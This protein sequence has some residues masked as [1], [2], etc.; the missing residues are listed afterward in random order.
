MP[1]P[2]RADWQ[3]HDVA[4]PIGP[5]VL[6]VQ[7]SPTVARATA[8][9]LSEGE[10]EA[11]VTVAD[12][13][14]A[15]RAELTDG[16]HALATDLLV[17]DLALPG[18]DALE[19]LAEVRAD[20]VSEAVPVVVLSGSS[21]QAVVQRSYQLGANCF[22]RK[23]NRVVDL[24]PATRAIERF[25]QRHADPQGGAEPMFQLPL[26]P[27]ASAVRDARRSVRDLFRAWGLDSLGEI[28]ELCTSEL[29]TNAVL[30][31]RS[32]VLLI[33][34]A[35]RDSV[36]VEVEDEAP[37]Q[38]APGTLVHDAETGRGLALVDAMAHAWGVDQH[39]AG[40]T[41]WFEL[42]RPTE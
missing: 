41:V 16:D 27:T 5:R 32:P 42:R 10:L 33:V 2:A 7:D 19:L 12:S 23:P 9:L 24:V 3:A 21:D 13:A 11:R 25:W 17:I 36:R 8:R 35:L 6:L 14:A 37:G 34:V 30:H 31:A 39:P 38:L 20:P 28:A 26:T 15:A 18:E 1:H 22:I 40:K 29:A 4:T